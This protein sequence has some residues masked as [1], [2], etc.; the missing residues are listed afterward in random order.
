MCF[1]M[2]FEIWLEFDK[3]DTIE[4]RKLRQKQEG[5]MFVVD[6]GESM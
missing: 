1:E 3:E 2:Y 4:E 6:S 5:E